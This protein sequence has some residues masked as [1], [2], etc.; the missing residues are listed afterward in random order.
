MTEKLT[1]YVSVSLACDCTSVVTMETSLRLTEGNVR[2]LFLS[3]CC[4]LPK[5]VTPIVL[6]KINYKHIF[7][8]WS[9]C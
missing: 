5:C 2:D 7:D 9:L 8:V 6:T 4:E 1:S 3:S